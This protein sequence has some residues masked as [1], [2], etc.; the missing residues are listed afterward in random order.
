M[1]YG[2]ILISNNMKFFKR[3]SLI[4]LLMVSTAFAYISYI[5]NRDT[6]GSQLSLFGPDIAEGATCATVISCSTGGTAGGCS[7]TGTSSS[8]SAG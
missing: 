6:E 5:L 8:S 7:G 1:E 3:Y 2:V 4:M